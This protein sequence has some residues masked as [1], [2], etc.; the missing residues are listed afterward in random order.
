MTLYGV[1]ISNWQAGI[2]ISEIAAEGFSWIEAK[3]SEGDYLQDPTWP[4]FLASAQAI[5]LPII[6]YHYAIAD[7]A[8]AA[9]VRTWLANN[10]GPN[11]M[12]DFESDSGDIDDFWALVRAF[13]DVGVNVTLTYLPQ[14]YWERIGSPDLSQVPGLVASAYPGGS[15]YARDIYAAAGGDSGEGWTPYGNAQPLIWQFSDQASIVGM[16]LDANAFR[17]DIEDLIALIGGDMTPQQAQ[18]L[19]DIWDQLRGPNGQGWPQLGHNGEGR[20]L[21]PVD[22]L[23]GLITTVNDLMAEVRTLKGAIKP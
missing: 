15:G 6:G 11:A 17:G 12:I 2:S 16:K 23:A 13:D 14:W 19:Q 4:E 10:G 22:A 3:V 8:P 18:Q 1:D 21:T 5:D 9:Q 7:C 20:N